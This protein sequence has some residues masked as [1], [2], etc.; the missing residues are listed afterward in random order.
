MKKHICS[1]SLALSLLISL[2]ACN[3]DKKAFDISSSAYENITVAYEIV[4]DFGTDIYEAWRMGIYDKDEI[5]K[6]G[7]EYLAKELNL[8]ADEIRDGMANLFHSSKWDDATVEELSGYRTEADIMF[9]LV[10]DDLF[11][12]CVATVA[13][14]Y[15]LNGKIDEAQSALDA[16][17]A[18]MK[19]LSEKYSDY[20]HY[21]N[22][23]GYYTTTSSFLDFC[24]N[25]TG[26]FEQ[27]KTTINDYK[28]DARDYVNDL[29][30]IFEE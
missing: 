7:A 5:H 18:Q 8:S 13:N 14:A 24:Q 4:E 19:E 22:L 30:Y 28:N 29:D 10:K 20:E 16:A 3:G 17:K 12:L 15:K 2:C 25:P 26:S 11:S 21:P 9:T 23:K 27:I 1:I 6:D